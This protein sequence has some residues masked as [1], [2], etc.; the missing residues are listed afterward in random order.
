MTWQPEV[1][2]PPSQ[3]RWLV[4]QPDTVFSIDRALIKDLEFLYTTP[5]AWSFTR[6]FHVE[7]LNKLRMESLI[8]DM[9]EKVQ[10]SI[11]REWGMDTISWKEVNIESTMRRVLVQITARVIV[12][13]PICRKQDYLEC[14]HNFMANLGPSAAFISFAPQLLR[15]I[16][17]WWFSRDLKKWNAVCADYMMPLVKQEMVHRRPSDQKTMPP[18]KTLLEQMARL[19]VRSSNPKDSDPFS[20]SS[21]LLALNFVAVHTSNAA[22]VNGLVD[23][24]SPPAGTEVYE[25]LRAE[26]EEVFKACNGKWSKSSVLQLEKIDSALRESLRLSTF[27]A[28]GVERVVVA[29]KGVTLPDGTYLPKNTKVG[30]PVLPI[31]LDHDIYP[32]AD[33]YNAFRFC[34]SSSAGMRDGS[35]SAS[36]APSGHVELINTSETF[37]AFGHGKHAW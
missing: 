4:E 27:K 8:E 7:A 1:V 21:R 28:R 36:P 14:A 34:T 10:D 6:P 17:G 3:I 11:D 33:K 30:V 15:P 29:K 19:A 37:L 35:R 23:I 2:L 16:A 12:G 9:A 31:H 22:L 20:V 32:D 18:P 25:E 5:A 24:M 26:A 13:H